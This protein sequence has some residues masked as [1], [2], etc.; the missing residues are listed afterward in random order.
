M[1]TAQTVLGLA[2]LVFGVTLIVARHRI[3]ERRRRRASTMPA[4]PIL[5]LALGTMMAMNGALQLVL[6]L[7]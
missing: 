4:G 2:L 1:A 5:W 6:G 7:A 3:G